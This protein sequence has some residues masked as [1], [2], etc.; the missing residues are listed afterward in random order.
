MLY[1]LWIHDAPIHFAPGKA[2]LPT[3]R[4]HSAYLSPPH[5]S[6]LICDNISSH[7]ILLSLSYNNFESEMHPYLDTFNTQHCKELCESKLPSK[8]SWNVKSNLSYC[9]GRK[10]VR[11]LNPGS[12]IYGWQFVYSKGTNGP[13]CNA[14]FKN[15]S[16][17]E[18]CWICTVLECSKRSRN[19]PLAAVDEYPHGQCFILLVSCPDNIVPPIIINLLC[20]VLH[21]VAQTIFHYCQRGSYPTTQID[22]LLICYHLSAVTFLAIAQCPFPTEQPW[23]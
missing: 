1:P 13:M 15:Y 9:T 17:M 22:L 21:P 10:S 4:Y 8:S 11:L 18:L 3:K 7:P 20:P 19:F 16:T 2:I 23:L 12:K 14:R 5:L 6:P